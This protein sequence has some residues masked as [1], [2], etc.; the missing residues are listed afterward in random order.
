M[1]AMTSR[2]VAPDRLRTP[3]FIIGGAMK[4]GTTTLHYMLGQHPQVFI[5]DQ[6]VN[7][8]DID[9]LFQHPDFNH[10]DGSQWVRQRLEDDPERFWAWYAAHFEGAGQDQRVG[11]DSTTYLSSKIAARRIAMQDKPIKLIILL[12]HPTDRAYS[13][14]WH[15][16]RTGR[17]T[18]SFEDTLRYDPFAVLQRSLYLDQLRNLFRYIPPERVKVVVF[19]AFMADK[20][21]TLRE[22][23]E[24]IG[25][26]FGKLPQAAVETHKNGSLVPR[27]PRLEVAK[28]RL[29]RAG[30]S[31]AYR[32]RLP[33]CPASAGARIDLPRLVNALHRR[34][35]PLVKARP[36]A[37]KP[38]TRILLDGYFQRELDGLDELLGRPVMARW[39]AP[40]D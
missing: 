30:G 11:E 37:M 6:E 1:R 15:L 26:D 12:R 20:Q 38:A 5:P 21:G 27:R 2:W 31:L 8:F 25:V 19:E 32:A 10:F 33:M 3:D 9:D 14:Y 4:S 16:V 34:I 35:N 40:R 29:F 22:V 17:A 18:Y 23:C 13:Q 7:F 24:H 28:N 36:P 39:F